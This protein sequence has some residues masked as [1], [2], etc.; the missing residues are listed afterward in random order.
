LK[1]DIQKIT[2]IHCIHYGAAWALLFQV[3]SAGSERALP[4]V[5]LHDNLTYICCFVIII[6]MICMFF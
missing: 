3:S 5:R 6:Y 4:T 2:A 1:A